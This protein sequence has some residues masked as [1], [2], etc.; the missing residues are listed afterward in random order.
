MKTTLYA[1]T[2]L[3][4]IIISHGSSYAQWT[5]LSTTPFTQESNYS[6]ISDEKGYSLDNGGVLIT[7]PI[8]GG[9]NWHSISTPP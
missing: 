5:T 9:L 8:N 2:I 3:L 4:S 7:K 1:L 6:F